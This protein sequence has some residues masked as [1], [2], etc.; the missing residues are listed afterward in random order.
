MR[1]IIN[2]L[3]T[4]SALFSVFADVNELTLE[5]TEIDIGVNGADWRYQAK[6][7]R[8]FLKGTA[9]VKETGADNGPTPEDAARAYCELIRG[10]VLVML[11]TVEKLGREVAVPAHLQFDVAAENWIK[12]MASKP[13]ATPIPPSGS[14]RR[15]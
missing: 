4:E 7:A 5:I 14:I 11:P 8:T 13:P 12:A 2:R 3:K 9:S 10:E 15:Y 6:F 1:V